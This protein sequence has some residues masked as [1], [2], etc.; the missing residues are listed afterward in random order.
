MSLAMATY[1]VKTREGRGEGLHGAERFHTAA[2]GTGD[3]L[4]V[5]YHPLVAQPDQRAARVGESVHLG[6][7][8]RLVAERDLPAEVEQAVDV[9]QRGGGGAGGTCLS[10]LGAGGE[11]FDEFAGPVDVDARAAERVGGVAEQFECFVVGQ[12]QLVGRGL[13]EQSPEWLPD[14]GAAAQ[15]Q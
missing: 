1:W 9:E 6:F 8:E 12:P 14:P 4:R 15:S 13:L 7:G 2:L 11:G 3:E 10:D 5:G